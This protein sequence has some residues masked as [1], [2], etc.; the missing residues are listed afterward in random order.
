MFCLERKK[1]EADGKTLVIQIGDRGDGA[2]VSRSFCT[3][4]SSVDV[5]WFINVVEIQDVVNKWRVRQFHWRALV[6]HVSGIG[7]ERKKGDEIIG[8]GAGGSGCG[9]ED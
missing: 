8:V 3:V 2:I 4:V 1:I 5:K 7:A 9:H 6:G